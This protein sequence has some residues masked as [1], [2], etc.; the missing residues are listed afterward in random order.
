MAR[1]KG[2]PAMVTG[3]PLAVRVLPAMRTVLPIAPGEGVGK[4]RV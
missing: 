1:L 4:V 3:E 2:I